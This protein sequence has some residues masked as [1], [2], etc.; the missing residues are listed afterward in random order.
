M[1]KID[2]IFLK[3]KVISLDLYL[4]KVLYDK[5]IGYYQKKN[6]FG[7]RGDFVTA[8][9]ISNLFSEMVAIG[10]ISFWENLKKPKSLNFIE[11]GPGNGDFCMILIKT[12]KNF[13]KAFKSINIILYEKSSRL[14]KIQKNCNN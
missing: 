14:K 9:N 4:D 12:L 13:P 11:M 10:L 5:G 3:K 8:P 6:P 7:I 1:K 2:K